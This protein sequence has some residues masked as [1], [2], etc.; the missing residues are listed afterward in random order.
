[1]AAATQ[2]QVCQLDALWRIQRLPQQCRDFSAGEIPLVDGPEQLRLQQ[3]EFNVT[4]FLLQ[5]HFDMPQ[6]LARIAVG[7]ARPRHGEMCACIM[8]TERKRALHWLK[9][10]PFAAELAQTIAQ[11]GPVRRLPWF[12]PDQASVHRKCFVGARGG[13]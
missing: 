4:R 3:M 1:M 10:L 6:A 8:C 13:A 5:R 11:V 7:I 12:Q 2:Q 9:R